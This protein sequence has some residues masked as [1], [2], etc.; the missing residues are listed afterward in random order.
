MFN[1]KV[2]ETYMHHRNTTLREKVNMYDNDIVLLFRNAIAIRLL[3]IVVST[4]WERRLLLYG[5][6]QKPLGQ[7]AKPGE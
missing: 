3:Y 1:G 4:Q 7:I 6:Q 5:P 2:E